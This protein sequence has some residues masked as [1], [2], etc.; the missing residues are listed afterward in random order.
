MVSVC[1]RQQ[2]K[3]KDQLGQRGQEWSLM[4]DENN[5]DGEQRLDSGYTVL[6]SMFECKCWLACLSPSRP[7]T[8]TLHAHILVPGVGWP[9]SRHPLHVGCVDVVDRPP[10]WE[11]AG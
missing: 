11:V 7:Q 8:L 1:R 5:G 9:P 2:W 10:M 4:P 3:L 6:L